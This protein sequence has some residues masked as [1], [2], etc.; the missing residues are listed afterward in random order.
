MDQVRTDM[1][2]MISTELMHMASINANLKL[3]ST[4]TI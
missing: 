4:D 2:K 3:E 1:R